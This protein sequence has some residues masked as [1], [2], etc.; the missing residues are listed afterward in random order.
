[1]NKNTIQIFRCSNNAISA[2]QKNGVCYIQGFG[3][4]MEP[5]LHAGDIFRFS[6][7]TFKTDIVAT[8]HKNREPLL[9]CAIYIELPVS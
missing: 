8:M 1:M 4:S 3:N 7:V 9:H 2:I 5:F 6:L